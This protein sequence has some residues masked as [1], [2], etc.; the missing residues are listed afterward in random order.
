M[1]MKN[2]NIFEPALTNAPA[3]RIIICILVCIFLSVSLLLKASEPVA[4]FKPGD[5][6]YA[7]FRIPAIVKTGKGILLAFAEARKK[8]CSD[9]GDIDLVLRRSTD[10]GKTWGPLLLIRDDGSNVAGNPAPVVDLETG[11][12]WLLSTWNLGTD[13]ESQIIDLTSKDTRRVFVMNSRDEGIT[14]SNP[15]EITT[16]VKNPGW[17]WYATGPVH[18]IQLRSKAYNGRLVI[19]CDHIEAVTNKYFSHVI[20]SDDHGASWKTGGTTPQDMVNEC[21]VAELPDGRLILN[22]R[23]YDR[24]Q[25]NRKVSTSQDGGESWSDIRDDPQLI[26]PICQAALLNITM[27]GQQEALFFLNPADS[28]ARRNMTLKMSHDEGRSWETVKTIHEGPA[29]YSDLVQLNSK[30]LACL[31]E[32]GKLSAYEGIWFIKM[33]IREIDGK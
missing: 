10:G 7:C 15:T 9:A 5:G 12:V 2:Y 20:Y 27:K 31:Y 23:N 22:M 21:T 13:R 18:G 4:L 17:T 29:A 24:K 30:E 11:T 28:T 6:G 19:P 14:W 25:K 26:E 3:N 33:K 16:D 1:A 32:A 8:G